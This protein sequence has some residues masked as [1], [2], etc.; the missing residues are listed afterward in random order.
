L[1]LDP[2]KPRAASN[3]SLIAALALFLE[4]ALQRGHRDNHTL[5]RQVDMWQLVS[6]NQVINQALAAV[7]RMRPLPVG[8]KPGDQPLS[9]PSLFSSGN[10]SVS[11]TFRASASAFLALGQG[12]TL[13]TQAA[14]WLFYF[15]AAKE[16]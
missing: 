3:I 6:F 16:R 8:S 1:V 4:V 13:D 5:L 9:F 14:Q 15:P 10:T 12:A 11:A 7:K 2:T